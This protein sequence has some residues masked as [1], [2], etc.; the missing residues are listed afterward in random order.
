MDRRPGDPNGPRIQQSSQSDID[1]HLCGHDCV[2][3]HTAGVEL[4]SALCGAIQ[5]LDSIDRSASEVDAKLAAEA[6]HGL[7]GV[8]GLLLGQPLGVRGCLEPFKQGRHGIVILMYG[9][10][11][12]LKPVELVL[13]RGSFK[14]S[15]RYVWCLSKLN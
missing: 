11:L 13:E 4:R 15:H 5:V 2:S 14:V 6:D 7:R 12:L 10:G 1:V 3:T 8:F 9:G